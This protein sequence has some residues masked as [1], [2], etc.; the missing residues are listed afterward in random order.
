MEFRIKY[1]YTETLSHGRYH[2]YRIQ[3]RPKRVGFIANLFNFWLS[4]KSI[5]EWQNVYSLKWQIRLE[6]NFFFKDTAE[7]FLASYR[8]N[9]QKFIQN[10]EERFRKYKETKLLYSKIKY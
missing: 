1:A 7:E 8:K 3:Y 10:T 2:Y 9:P 6:T 5:K 4:T